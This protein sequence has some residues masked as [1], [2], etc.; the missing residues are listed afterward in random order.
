MC[1]NKY[2]QVSTLLIGVYLVERNWLGQRDIFMQSLTRV[3]NKTEII[4]WNKM[5][6]F[7]FSLYQY[8]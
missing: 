3:V 4:T 2:Y 6:V 5:L 1:S 7:V 8:M